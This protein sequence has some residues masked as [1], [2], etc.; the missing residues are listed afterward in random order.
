MHFERAAVLFARRLPVFG[1]RVC[2]QAVGFLSMR[3]K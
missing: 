3:T 2:I 1:R